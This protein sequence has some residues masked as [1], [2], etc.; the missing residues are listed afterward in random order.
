MRRVRPRPPA[1]PVPPRP[2]CRSASTRIT[3]QLDHISQCRATIGRIDGPPTRSY[4]WTDRL[5]VRNYQGSGFTWDAKSSPDPPRTSS[6][7][8]SLVPLP[9]SPAGLRI[10]VPGL[11]AAIK[12]FTRCETFY[13]SPNNERCRTGGKDAPPHR[14]YRS[15]PALMVWGLGIRVQ[16]VGFRF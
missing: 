12:S 7:S 5:F 9:T 6:A 14:W 8:S 10:R 2:P 15:P 11:L 1:P 16:G 4:R 13:P 3:T